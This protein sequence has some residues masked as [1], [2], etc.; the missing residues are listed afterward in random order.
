M[1]PTSSPVPLQEAFKRRGTGDFDI[2]FG[3]YGLADPDPEGVMS[4]YFEETAL[5]W[6]PGQRSLLQDSISHGRNQTKQKRLSQMRSILGDAF[7]KGY[8]LPLFHLSTIGLGR[9][10]L[11]FSSIPTSEESVT[12]SKIR[13]K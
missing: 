3:G 10:E 6:L 12:L 9:A 4:F 1:N 11:D 13:F 5:W 8:F 2:Y 7:C